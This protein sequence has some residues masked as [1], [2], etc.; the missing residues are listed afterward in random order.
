MCLLEYLS[1]DAVTPDD[2]DDEDAA[3]YPGAAEECGDLVDRNCDGSV[4]DADGDGDGAVA[5]EDCDD[6]DPTIFPDAPEVC[7]GID[8]DCDTEVDEGLPTTTRYLD[9]DGDGYGADDVTLES[10]EDLPD[11]VSSGGDCDDADPSVYP[12]AEESCE[13]LVDKNCDGSVGADDLDGDG[14]IACEDCDDTDEFTYPGAEEVCDEVDNNCDGEIDE[15]LETITLYWDAD[16]D[17][18]GLTDETLET[19]LPFAEGL[20]LIHISEPTRPY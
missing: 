17:G 1:V 7:D 8:N 11:F 20:S 16:L 19:C 12:G 14:T 15:G 2:C 10:C 6:S 3:T 9:D 13:D 18:Y 4:A 5:C